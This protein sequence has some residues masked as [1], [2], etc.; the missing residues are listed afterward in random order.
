[1]N[2]LLFA[3]LIGFMMAHFAQAQISLKGHVYDQINRSPLAGAHIISSGDASISNEAGAFKISVDSFPATLTVSYIGYLTESISI[4][5]NAP[6]QILL[7]PQST[8]LSQVVVSSGLTTDKIIN[9]SASIALINPQQLQRDQPFSLTNA[10]NRVPGVFMHSGTLN[11]NRITIRGMGSR[12]LFA[13]DKIKAYYDQ[14]PLTDGSGNSTLEDLDQSLISQIEI[15]KGPNSS[16]FGAG[17]GGVIQIRSAQ[18]DFN[19]TSLSTGWTVG[20]YGT[21]RLLGQFSHSSDKLEFN[22]IYNNTASDGYRANNRFKKWQTGMTGRYYFKEDNYLSFI[23]VFTDLHSQIPSSLGLDAFNN[24]PKSAATN[25]QEAKGY[26]DYQR[27]YGGVGYH[28]RLKQLSLSHSVNIQYKDAYE[29]GPRP[30]NII[31]DKIFGIGTRNVANYS[32][33]KWRLSGGLEWFQDKHEL[34]EYNNLHSPTSNGSVQG[35]MLDHLKE[36][37]SY[38]NLFSEISFSPT[39]RLK[40]VGGLNFNQTHYDLKDRFV[41]EG[42]DITGNYSFN[43]IWSPRF[44]SVFHVNE[45]MHLFT[46]ISHGF[47]PPNLEQTLYP[48]GQINSDIQPETGWNFE[49]GLRGEEIGWHYDVAVYF[50]DIKNLLVNQRT[51]EDVYIGVNAGRNHHY[52]AEVNLVYKKEFTSGAVFQIFNNLTLSHF[53][54]KKFVDE[55]MVYS[56]NKLTGVPAINLASGIEW[57]NATGFYGNINGQFTGKMPITDDNILFSKS[58]LLLRSKAGYRLQINKFMLDF[59]AGIDN[60]TNKHYAAMLL[61]NSGTGRYYYPGLPRNFYSGLLLTYNIR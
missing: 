30:V 3:Y 27:S 45:N 40:I 31:G 61:I 11:T 42:I 59:N 36:N 17:L 21:S 4:N 5:A 28:Y 7:A 29:P 54:F 44:G 33:G 46:N 18:P 16:M 49:A 58:Y 48:D 55:E 37:R 60:L 50:M 14:I 39:D 56:G 24:T 53:R 2:K 57:L 13:T 10:F 9:M 47:S 41:S 20:S 32:A 26:E 8:E 12:S 25:W 34:I 38:T 52:G 19:H 6:I 51:I 23:G 43:A 22:L 1:M 15:I 35:E